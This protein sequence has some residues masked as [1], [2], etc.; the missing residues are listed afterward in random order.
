MVPVIKVFIGLAIVGIVIVAGLLVRYVVTGGMSDSP[1][2]EAERGV[3]A[4]QEAVKANP[5]DPTA[6]I[7]LAAA[8]LEQDSPGLA[9]E[10]AKVAVRLAPKDPAAFYILGLV[11]LKRDDPGAAVKNLTKAAT[12]DG[13]VGQFY[14]DAYLALARALERTGDTSATAA[15]FQ[16]SLD[17]GPENSLVLFERGQFFERNKQW[18]NAIYDYGWALTYAPNYEPARAAFDKL[19]KAHPDAYKKV[20]KLASDESSA[21]FK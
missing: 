7:K 10:Q 4:A 9:E 19:A 17:Q 2:S 1:R 5:Q 8:Y 11:N 12:T 13:Q 18:A 6:R 14:Q 20:Q 16:K 21:A 3:V 15:A